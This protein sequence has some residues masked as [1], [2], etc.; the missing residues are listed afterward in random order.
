MELSN[1]GVKNL[2]KSFAP[3]SVVEFLYYLKYRAQRLHGASE[4]LPYFQD[5]RGI[6]IGGPSVVFRVILPVYPV[7]SGLDCVNFSDRTMWE[8]AICQGKTFNYYGNKTG[9]QFVAE[10]TDLR[11]IKSDGYDFLLSSNCLEHVAN[12]L[13]A[14]KEWVRV[15]SP[16]GYLL[17]VLPNKKSNFDHKRQITSFEHLLDDYRNNT[18]EH[19]L[20]HLDEILELHDLSRDPPAGDYENFKRRSL[21][22]F[23]NRGLHHHVFDLAL[24]EQ[25]FDYIGITLVRGD[26]TAK[27]YFALGRVEK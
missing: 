7:I 5:K 6:E 20:T 22:N 18:T 11:V 17:L 19:D 4:Y 24:I 3:K 25:I 26:E 13:K 23:H 8:G 16:A 21:D 2:V 12:P 10:A 15:V 9:N 27:D 14:L 1:V